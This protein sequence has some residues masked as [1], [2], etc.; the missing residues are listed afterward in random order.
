MRPISSAL[1]G[2]G[3][4]EQFRQP[5]LPIAY[6]RAVDRVNVAEFHPGGGARW[7]DQHQ[8]RREQAALDGSRCLAVVAPDLPFL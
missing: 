2:D 1:D 3:S 7:L 4:Q 5:I 8:I 6:R